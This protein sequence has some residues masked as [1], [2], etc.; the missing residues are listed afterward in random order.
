MEHDAFDFVLTGGA[1]RTLSSPLVDAA[2]R[3]LQSLAPSCRPTLPKVMPVA[4]AA[5]LALE[6]ACVPVDAGLFDR[7]VSQGHGWHPEE[8]FD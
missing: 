1:L 7:L 8:V 6:R 2:A 5:L 4:G 3:R